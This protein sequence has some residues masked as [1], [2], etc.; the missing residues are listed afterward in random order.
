MGEK[1][2]PFQLFCLMYLFELG[3]AIVVGL[4]LQAKQ[5][6]WL[7]ILLG[8]VGGLCLFQIYHYLYLQ[9][10]NQQLTSYITTILG[11]FIGLPISIIYCLYFLYIAARVLRDFGDLLIN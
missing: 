1:I 2:S 11:K 9:F 5:D 7:A 4:G 10:P 6:A 8:M 3:S